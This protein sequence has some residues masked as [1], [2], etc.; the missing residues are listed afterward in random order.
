METEGHSNYLRYTLDSEYFVE[1]KIFFRNLRI[2][3]EEPN[4]RNMC[5]LN[6]VLPSN[7]FNSK[8][9]NEEIINQYFINA[10]TNL[11]NEDKIKIIENG[12]FE[13]YKKMLLYCV[14]DEKIEDN[15][16]TDVKNIK[17]IDHEDYDT[18]ISESSKKEIK[19]ENS[20]NKSF[21]S[22]TK[23]EKDSMTGI[24]NRAL[25]LESL[26]NYYFRQFPILHLPDLIMNLDYESKSKN[27]NKPSSSINL[28][29][30]WDGCYLYEGESDITF[31]TD[32]ILPFNKEIEYKINK[33]QD[34]EKV[35]ND[36]LIRNN[37]ITLIEVKTHFP[38]E[39]EE[40]HTNNLE[41][42]IKTMFI[43]LNYFINLYA[44]I[45]KK[46]FK[47]IKIVLL[48]DQNRLKNYKN[49]IYNYLEKHK[50]LFQTKGNFELYFDLLYIIPSIGKISLNH[51]SQQ[52]FETKQKLKKLEEDN[53]KL[54]KLEEED[55][56]KLKK[57]EEDN[58]KLKKLEEES[59]KKWEAND[60]RLKKLEKDNK[61]L[62]K[63]EKDNERIKQ[64]EEDKINSNNRIK[65]LEE[66]L[67]KIQRSF[68]DDN[69][70]ENN[71]N[72][73]INS[74]F[75]ENNMLKKEN[76]P[77]INEKT[78]NINFI[79]ET[80]KLDQSQEKN[81]KE[82]ELLDTKE[83]K[84]EANQPESNIDNL[85]E[86]QSGI[87]ETINKE[88]NPC[89]VKKINESTKEIIIK[90][91]NENMKTNDTILVKGEK[92][93][94]KNEK[95]S[96][97]NKDA[98][99]EIINKEEKTIKKNINSSNSKKNISEKI[100]EN[101][102]NKSSSKKQI[103]IPE[104]ISPKTK[105]ITQKD[106]IFESIQLKLKYNEI[107]SEEENIYLEIYNYCKNELN[108]NDFSL[109]FYQKNH[110]SGDKKKFKDI[111]HKALK[112]LPKEKRIIFF[113]SYKFLPCMTKC[114]ELIENN[115]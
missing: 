48:Y 13:Y 76:V 38:K 81:N 112:K 31:S 109:I 5:L 102:K 77:E 97:D 43:K 92:I 32:F 30:E 21:K 58:K 78:D 57:L 86:Y 68:K 45:L 54:K 63:L 26:V 111:F 71:I 101:N 75:N 89:E 61:R 9:K 69:N 87:N 72:K 12:L 80:E 15:F 1:K 10:S 37:S 62:K 11:Q 110:T 41:N 115:Q 4:H 42:V 56:K 8:I 51:I 55:N 108:I 7:D 52:L 90:T 64:L 23:Y 22:N 39:K 66:A 6:K 35:Q 84:K 74:K 95:N 100:K 50:N 44:K 14:K 19:N 17:C 88:L 107:L 36:I 33:Y 79:K 105:N 47:E 67:K 24:K 91:V 29:F 28:F 59:K 98:K 25:V 34:T 16:L 70:K 60:E 106:E 49:N 65:Y 18:P 83:K 99:N 93:I 82:K 20:D 40:D 103:F 73:N 2:V 85:M 96:E 53:K 94:L 104:A 114:N 27:K 46:T 113:D 3:C